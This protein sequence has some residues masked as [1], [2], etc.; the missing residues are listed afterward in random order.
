MQVVPNGIDAA[1]WRV[2]ARARAA[3]RARHG[4]DGPLV[5]FA[6]RLVHEKGVQTLLDAIRPLRLAHPGLRLAVAGTGTFEDELH[7]H[8][9]K[10][11]IA[12]AVDWLGFVEDEEVAPL[13]AAADVVAVP[14]LYEPFGIVALEAA[15]ARA[16]V[17]VAETGGL[18]DL[19]T[20]GV[21][22]GSHRPGDAKALGAGD[23]R[24]LTD[25]RATRA[26]VERATRV[27]KRDYTWTAVAEP[28]P[29]STDER[30]AADDPTWS[31]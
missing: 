2:P 31:V 10:L 14:S 1:R 17:V 12:R 11:R 8:A 29:A 13:L 3:A 27:I 25:P 28:P 23:R 22:A 4:G 30:S 19:V 7:E 5:V 20:D 26:A 15:A 6:G 18:V 21:A 9:R 24:V 16:P